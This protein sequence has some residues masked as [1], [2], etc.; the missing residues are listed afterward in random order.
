MRISTSQIYDSALQ[1]MERS[2][3]QLLKLQNQLS[4]GRRM[5][6]PADD[7]VASARALAVTQ[8]REVTAQYARNQGHASDRLG[9]VDS[10]LSALND[11]LQSVRSR[12]V[13]AGNTVLAD[14]DRQAIAIE[15]EAR[16]DEMLA[17][18]NSRSAEGDYLFAGFQGATMPFARSAATA[19]TGASAVAY[20][21]DDGQRLLQV[22]SS[23]QMPSNVAGSDLF[24]NIREGN[25]RFSTA[26]GGNGGLANQGSGSIDA[27]SVLDHQ[28]WQDAINTAFPWQ[29]TNNRS[30]QVVFSSGTG[31]TTYQL[32]DVSTPAPPS[33]PLPPL[34]VSDVRPFSPGQAIPLLTT[35]QPPAAPLS[36]DFGAQVV[37]SGQPA[38][39]D[40]FAVRPSANKSVFQTM[41][42]LIALL[43]SPLDS[44]TARG[45]FASQLQG[46]LSNLDQ[47]LAKVS[48][49]Q[50]TV[51]AHLQELDSL[52]SNAAALDIQYQQTLSNLQDLDYAQAISDFTRQQVGLEAAQKSFVTISGL[53]LFNYL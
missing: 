23:Q 52:S 14:T 26:G 18:A 28:K 1:G 11:S 3:S 49:V 6:T 27:G 33:A 43:R 17:I 44:S 48:R 22:S 8:A 46:H 32:F 12:V 10:Q 13:Q 16:L 29:G 21:G 47:A 31:G 7:P 15:L 25:G 37:I 51:G 53:S 34:A 42:E 39:G 9:L 35:A 2:N 45:D 30:L 41:D 19:P 36:V 40:T 24:M 50:S 4:S 5:L 38:A 20:F